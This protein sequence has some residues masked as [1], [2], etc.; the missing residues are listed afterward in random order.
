[1]EDSEKKYVPLTSL[2]GNELNGWKDWG[3]R[4]G[5]VGKGGEEVNEGLEEGEKK[6]REGKR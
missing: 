2:G 3:E 5:K 1:M 4:K 6:G